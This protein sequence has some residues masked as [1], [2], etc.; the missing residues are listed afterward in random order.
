MTTAEFVFSNKY[1]G[2]SSSNI[3]ADTENHTL[4]RFSNGFQIEYGWVTNMPS[5]ANLMLLGEFVTWPVITTSNY[6]EFNNVRYAFDNSNRNRVICIN[7]N[8]NSLSSFYYQ[9]IGRWK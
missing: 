4:I 7:E 1:L 2:K 9:A 3:D 8:E 6:Y 5:G